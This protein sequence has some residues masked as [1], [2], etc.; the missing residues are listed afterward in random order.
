MI[1][2]AVSSADVGMMENVRIMQEVI[3]HPERLLQDLSNDGD[4]DNYRYYLHVHF[5][6]ER[7]RTKI[8]ITKPMLGYFFGHGHGFSATSTARLLHISL[9]TLCRRMAEFGMLICT[10]YSNISDDDLDRM[11]Q[12]FQEQYPNCGYRMMQGHLK[13][14]N[15][16]VQQSRVR[17]AMARTDPHGVINRWCNTVVRRTYS[18]HSPNALWHIDGNHRLIRYA[19]VIKIMYMY[20]N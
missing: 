20:M 4:C 5:T 19:C 11:I 3:D 7:G 13:G 8:E 2:L 15:H 17:E 9:S 12:S 10:Q 1:L 14:L 18:V 6:G 16:R